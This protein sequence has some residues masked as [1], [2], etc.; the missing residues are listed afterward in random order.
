M[1]KEKVTIIGS[2]FS[3]PKGGIV[4]VNLMR[5]RQ[6]FQDF[7]DVVESKTNCDLTSISSAYRSMTTENQGKVDVA[8]DYEIGDLPVESIIDDITITIPGATCVLIGPDLVSRFLELSGTI[9]VFKKP[10]NIFETVI[11]NPNCNEIKCSPSTSQTFSIV[12]KQ[13]DGTPFVS[14]AGDFKATIIITKEREN[15]NSHYDAYMTDQIFLENLIDFS[16]LREL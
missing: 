10:S 16:D 5:L 2:D 11:T 6:D 13:L 1:S 14:L 15:V 7:L 12:N 3:L 9:L 8:S 4:Q